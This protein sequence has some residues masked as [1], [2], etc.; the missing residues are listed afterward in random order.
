VSLFKR[1]P[2]KR[3]VIEIRGA[4][5]FS[6]IKQEAG[7]ELGL[8]FLEESDGLGGER[9]LKRLAPRKA[10]AMTG[11][12]S[13]FMRAK[14]RRH[15]IRKRP[16]ELAVMRVVKI[17]D[18]TD[19]KAAAACLA[20]DC[21]LNSVPRQKRLKLGAVGGKLMKRNSGVLQE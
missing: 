21:G 6:R 18:G 13:A 10:E 17:E 5:D 7:I 12:Q 4:K 14:K 2:K 11:R 16:H 1:R 9:M 15:L 8:E 20:I 3:A 19:L